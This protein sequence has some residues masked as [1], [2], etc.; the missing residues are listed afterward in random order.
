[1][2]DL[3]TIVGNVSGS[4]P[5]LRFTAS[6]K[7]VCNFSV[8]VPGSKA[9]GDQPAVPAYFQD[10]VA[11]EQLGEN[12]AESLCKGDRVIVRGLIKD[13]S[14]TKDDGSEVVKQQLS[15]WNAGPDLSYVTCTVTE[16]E[17]A[18]GTSQTATVDTP[19][20]VGPYTSTPGG[21]EDF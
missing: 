9:K 20:H 17:E 13:N 16:V 2:S 15:A 8:K 18:D 5:V 7:A 21:L 11:W 19:E 14:Y 12:V 1:M 4:D 6:G 3:V 10:C